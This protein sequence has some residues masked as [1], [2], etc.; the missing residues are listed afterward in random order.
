MEAF[1][2]RLL[3]E[4]DVLYTRREKLQEFID[5]NDKFNELSDLQKSLLI[6]QNHFM[7]GYQECLRMRI[8]DLISDEEV[9]DWNNRHLDK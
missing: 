8:N 2:E 4:H 5:N 9:D 3:E 7:L 1:K 6:S